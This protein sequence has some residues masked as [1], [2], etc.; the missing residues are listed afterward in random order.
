MPSMANNSPASRFSKP[1][2]HAHDLGG[3]SV[4]RIDRAQNDRVGTRDDAGGDQDHGELPDLFVKTSLVGETAHDSIGPAQAF[5]AHPAQRRRSDLKGRYR[6]VRTHELNDP[7]DA[8]DAV[9]QFGG[10]RRPRHVLAAAEAA[11]REA[12]TWERM[13]L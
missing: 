11:N 4:H 9:H 1:S 12:R 7:V 3:H 10:L 2:S 8:R 13:P 5:E 6:R